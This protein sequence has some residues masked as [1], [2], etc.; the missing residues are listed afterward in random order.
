[1]LFK[2]HS[3]V[4][5]M[6]KRNQRETESISKK[7]K[8]KKETHTKEQDATKSI[9]REKFIITNTH[10]KKKKVSNKQSYF[11]PQSTR[12]KAK[13]KVIRSKEITKI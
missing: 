7:K 2:Q 13:S 5:P 11:A 10:V 9:L 4:Q 3:P 12:N 8:K 1:M 6:V